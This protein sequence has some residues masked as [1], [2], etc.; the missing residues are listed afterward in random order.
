MLEDLNFYISRK[1]RFPLSNT[2]LEKADFVLF[3]IPFDSTQSGN[4]GAR[5]G[6][7]AIRWASFDL[8]IFDFETKVDLTLPRIC[9]IGDIECVPG[10]PELTRN[11]ILYTV[12]RVPKNKIWIGLGGEHSITYPL[13]ETL[14]PDIVISFDAHPDLRD[15]YMG[16]KLS[17]SSVMQRIHETGADI[18]ILG[19]RECSKE[20]YI[21]SK[22]HNISLVSP[23]D[24]HTFTLPKNKKVYLSIDLDVFE[25][26]LKVGN[27]VPGGV[28]FSQVQGLLNK[29]ITSNK[30]VGFDIVELCSDSRDA[31]S[32]FASKLLY[33]LISYSYASCNIKENKEKT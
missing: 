33:K 26:Y 22:K 10:S 29:I 1:M 15:N 20:E 9:D 23:E 12:K 18:N 3:G 5:Y 17:H 14:K 2:S 19:V 8:E 24:L 4:T 28:T 13:V 11:R 16:E 27:P 32:I 6:P 25:S 21:Y 7:T 30:V 31:S